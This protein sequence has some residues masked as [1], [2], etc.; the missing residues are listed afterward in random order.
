MSDHPTIP[1]RQALAD[2]CRRHNIEKLALF[3]SALGDE[4]SAS[5]DIDLLVTFCPR[6]KIGLMGVT[7]IELALS[8]FFGNRKIDLRTRAELSPYIRDKVLSE[9]RLLIDLA[10]H[11]A[12]AS[13]A[14]L[15]HPGLVGDSVRTSDRLGSLVC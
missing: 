5:S 13:S 7:R 12:M 10:E 9:A 6:T 14:I 8:P 4:F 2:F 3:G 15:N 11:P 1:S